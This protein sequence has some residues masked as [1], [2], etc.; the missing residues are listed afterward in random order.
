MIIAN[1][2]NSIFDYEAAKNVI[3]L[4]ITR[5]VRK[6]GNLVVKNELT[7]HFFEKYP[8]LSKK[9]GYMISQSVEY[10]TYETQK[11]SLLGLPDRSH[12]ASSLN[13]EILTASLWYLK[14]QA[15][16]KF[17]CVFYVTEDNDLSKDILMEFF[18]EVDNIVMFR[19]EHKDE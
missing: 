7:K 19:K 1:V 17:D 18:Q 8:N 15:L 14:E 3:V 13:E 4:P 16:I 2:E 10:P 5:Y 9:W 6:D 12:Y 11:T